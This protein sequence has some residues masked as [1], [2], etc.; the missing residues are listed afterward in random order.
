MTYLPLI[1]FYGLSDDVIVKALRF[2][3][4]DGKAEVFDA[5]EGMGVKFLQT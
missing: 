2:L 5:G 4:K 1:E 3:E